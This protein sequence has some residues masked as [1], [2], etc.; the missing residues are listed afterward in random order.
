MVMPS[1]LKMRRSMALCLWTAVF[2][3][4]GT[5]QMAQ[6]ATCPYK[7]RLQSV[8]AAVA[9][10]LDAATN[11]TTS[12]ARMR[13][14]LIEARLIRIELFEG[15][16]PGG[17]RINRLVLRALLDAEQAIVIWNK[18]YDPDMAN[19]WLDRARQSLH[20]ARMLLKRLRCVPASNVQPSV[21]RG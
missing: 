8:V 6:A 14:L 10:Y 3:S 17:Q 12:E 2:L 18:Y 9:G 11:M 21:V 5:T 16:P 4:G 20:R 13:A 7:A 1:K 19:S 15:I